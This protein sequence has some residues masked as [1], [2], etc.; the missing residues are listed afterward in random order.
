MWTNE[1]ERTE[2]LQKLGTLRRRIKRRPHL[3]S[4]AQAILFR[5]RELRH[6]ARI[7]RNQEVTPTPPSLP[8]RYA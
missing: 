5:L 3:A 4:D 6:I 7:A 8:R 2:L 1:Q